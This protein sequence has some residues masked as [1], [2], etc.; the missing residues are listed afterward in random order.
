MVRLLQ[1]EVYSDYTIELNEYDL[2]LL[3]D[4]LTHL[5]ILETKDSEKP[6]LIYT[7]NLLQE[8]KEIKSQ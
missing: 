5:V 4:G 6:C 3:I 8:L 2:K 1:K 7:Y